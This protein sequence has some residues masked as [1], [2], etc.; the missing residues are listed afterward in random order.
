MSS[1]PTIPINKYIIPTLKLFWYHNILCLTLLFPLFISLFKRYFSVEI[2][3]TKLLQKF[4]TEFTTLVTPYSYM[5]MVS[6]LYFSFESSIY[7]IEL[8]LFKYTLFINITIFF[9]NHSRCSFVQCWHLR[10]W[11]AL[12]MPLWFTITFV[13]FTFRSHFSFSLSYLTLRDACFIGW[14]PPLL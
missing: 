10:L 12:M 1:P 5:K 13:I 6:L 3:A 8:P 11:K 4:H 9:T 7:F 2:S 14:S